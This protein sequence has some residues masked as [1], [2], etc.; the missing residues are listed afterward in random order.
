V[1]KVHSYGTLRPLPSSK[2]A[3]CEYLNSQKED[4]NGAPQGKGVRVGISGIVLNVLS[5]HNAH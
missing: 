1:F 4:E 3:I 2:R 5:T